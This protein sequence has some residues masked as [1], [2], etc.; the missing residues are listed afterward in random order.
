MRIALA[1]AAALLLD[2]PAAAQELVTDISRH[3]ISIE[4]NFTGADLL[5]FGAVE[6]P[7]FGEKTDIAIVVRGPQDDVV[8]RRKARVGGIWVNFDSVAFGDVPGYYSVVSTRPLDEITSKT[9]LQR[10]G[11]GIENLNLADMTEGGA[12]DAAFREAVLRLRARNKLYQSDSGGVVFLGKSLFRATVNMPANV[13]D[14][15]FSASIY[16]FEDGDLV[17]AQTTPL[18]VSK[19]GF[20][21]LVYTLANRQPLAYGILAV[22]LAVV[23]GWAASVAFRRG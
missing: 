4:S 1:I 7:P 21:R 11:I 18:Y 20:E 23:A 9:V 8:V 15:V 5:L 14:G 2:R 12:G 6:G 17:Q 13:P 22:V 16:L 3:L 19:A 10:H